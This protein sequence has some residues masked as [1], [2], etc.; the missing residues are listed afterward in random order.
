MIK[1]GD[2]ELQLENVKFS[3][4]FVTIEFAPVYAMEY[5][6]PNNNGDAFPWEEMRKNYK[7]FLT[8]GAVYLEHT[9]KPKTKIGFISK[10][11]LDYTMKR[12]IV[13]ADLDLTLLP[14]EVLNRINNKLAIGSSMG[15][16]VPFDICS[17]CGHMAKNNSERCKHIPDYLLEIDN[18]T[19]K[20]VY[21]I[22][23]SPIWYDLSIVASPALLLGYSLKFIKNKESGEYESAL[24]NFVSNPIKNYLETIKDFWQKD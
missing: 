17:V 19:K 1:K 22:N 12:I 7:T 18:E 2:S 16:E 23:Y 10:A 14:E 11:D 24:F 5:W 15:C 6:G 13:W 20:L 21:M 3:G 8:H 9:Y 4:K